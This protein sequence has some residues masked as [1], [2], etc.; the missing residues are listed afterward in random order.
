MFF[1]VV[2]LHEENA[3]GFPFWI[4]TSLIYFLLESML[5]INFSLELEY[6][7]ITSLST[8]FSIAMKAFFFTSFRLNLTLVDHNL[9]WGD[10][11]C[12]H[13]CHMSL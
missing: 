5:I 10:S 9:V 6:D 11:V 4:I 8:I 2:N 3:K 13:L 12:A 7:I 1:F